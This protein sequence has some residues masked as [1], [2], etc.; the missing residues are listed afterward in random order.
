MSSLKTCH[1]FLQ[2]C[3]LEQALHWFLWCKIVPVSSLHYLLNVN[4]NFLRH[5]NRTVI[6]QVDKSTT[7]S[8]KKRKEKNNNNFRNSGE[9][10]GSPLW[11]SSQEVKTSSASADLRACKSITLIPFLVS[12]VQ[13]ESKLLFLSCNLLKVVRPVFI[14]FAWT[15]G[16][17]LTAANFKAALIS[18]VLKIF[19]CD[20][21]KCEIQTILFVQ[22]FTFRMCL[23][24]VPCILT[25]AQ[26]FRASELLTAPLWC[27]CCL[28]KLVL[29]S[30]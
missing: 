28:L 18:C 27:K 22:L 1:D 26:T 23:S 9:I 5:Q 7:E 8:K 11:L 30:R 21:F 13:F 4:V 16:E 14:F 29:D 10:N 3:F 2:I 12:L 25:V 19:E 24:C 20:S 17:R 6:H 15:P